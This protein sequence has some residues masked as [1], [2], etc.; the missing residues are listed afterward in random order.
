MR[1]NVLL[2]LFIFIVA[3]LLV[4]FICMYL[5]DN[6]GKINQGNFR[7][8][9]VMT[10]SSLLVS[11]TQTVDENITSLSDIRLNADQEN[12]LSMLVVSNVKPQKVY[13]DNISVSNANLGNVAIYDNQNN[14]IYSNNIKV[15]TANITATDKDGQY[16]IEIKINNVGIIKDQPIPEGHNE[17]IYDGRLMKIY[18]LST[19]DIKFDVNF[20]VNIVD[21]NNKLNICKIKLTLPNEDLITNGVSIVRQPVADYIFSVK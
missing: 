8:N 10:K 14:E 7:V 9:D 19:K 2:K 5:L 20:N 15:E 16:L 13:I 12:I 4:V 11:E 21:E 1:G 18:G 6:T 3:I 17:V